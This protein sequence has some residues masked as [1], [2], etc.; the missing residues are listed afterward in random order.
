METAKMPHYH[1]W[2]KKTWY[3]YMMEFYSVTKKNEILSFPNKWMEVEN[4]IL[5]EVSQSQ[6]AKNHM[7]SLICGL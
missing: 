5:S 6:K 7:F 2:I 1:K 4:I 3:L